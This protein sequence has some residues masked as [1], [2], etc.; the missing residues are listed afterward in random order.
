MFSDLGVFIPSEVSK[1]SGDQSVEE[2]RRQLAEARQ[3]E[4]ATGGAAHHRSDC[5][6]ERRRWHR[7]PAGT[8]CWCRGFGRKRRGLVIISLPSTFYWNSRMQ[9]CLLMQRCAWV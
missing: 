9:V 8:N 4:A 2:L 5:A 3:R 1:A 6:A 7:V